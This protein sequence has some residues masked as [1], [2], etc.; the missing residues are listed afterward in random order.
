MKRVNKELT[1]SLAVLLLCIGAI[2]YFLNE[3]QN[4]KTNTRTDLFTL[5]PPESYAVLY[6]GNAVSFRQFLQQPAVSRLFERHLP[7]SY[8]SI[9]R[10]AGTHTAFLVAFSPEGC[11]LYGNPDNHHFSVIKKKVYE[12]PAA[13]YSP[14]RQKYAG[15]ELVYYP[16]GGKD[17]LGY[18]Y[19]DGILMTGYNKKLLEK[20][21]LQHK[22]VH[23]PDAVLEL[24]RKETNRNVPVNFLFRAQQFDLDLSLDSLRLFTGRN[25]W[26][27]AD[28][29]L[30]HDTLCAFGSV[31]LDAPDAKAIND[32]VTRLFADTLERRLHGLIPDLS[33][34]TQF[35]KEGN[36]LYYAVSGHSVST[37]NPSYE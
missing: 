6:I 21:V 33:F 27:S 35:S 9:I 25:G 26:V 2:G 24:L 36:Q 15:S 11:L 5:I 12:E 3:I 4:K 8:L 22:I 37:V 16:T 20:S 34:H 10:N 18:F 7:A 17:F 31:P 30:Q 28:C 14:L 23:A 19:Q 29:T 1:F 32:S 13:R